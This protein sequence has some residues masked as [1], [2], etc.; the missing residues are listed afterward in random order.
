MSTKLQLSISFAANPRTW[1]LI[2]GRV[3]VEGVDLVITPS[4]PSEIF[5]RQLKFGDFDISEMSMSSLMMALAH[6][7]DRFVGI[8]VFTTH[9]FFH[10]S[11]LVRRDAGIATPADL[12]GKR[13]GVP[14]YQQTA[15]L[16]TR[17]ALAHEWGV[18]AQDM[19][20]WME[21]P[22]SHS[23]GGATGFAPPPGVVIHQV[24][25]ETNLGAMVVEGK[26]D[27]VVHYIVN[28]NLVDRSRI[29]L[30]NHPAARRLFPDPIAEGIRYYKKTGL[31]PINH[32]MVI[33]RALAEKHPWVILNL[34]TA[35]E[36]AN[37]IAD[38]ERTEHVTDH[39]A[40]G[41]ILADA[42]D[43]LARPVLRH[44]IKAN[45]TI[46]ETC[47]DYSLEQGL[48]PRRMKLE[49]IFAPSTMG[50]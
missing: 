8:P 30:W 6:G 24:P 40:T 47:A 7:D 1:P 29:D 42:K 19:E 34:M 13:V 39:L 33:K 48:T 11:M 25:V 50:Q 21:R 4:H 27:A 46:L 9:R 35:F 49:E 38:R 32:G 15:A 23:H 20:W 45:R 22:P 43:A 44:G 31:Y 41:L 16:W 28:D 37:A 26:L 14:E 36:R 18:T 5:W 2:D 12:K 17:G 10:T 3:K